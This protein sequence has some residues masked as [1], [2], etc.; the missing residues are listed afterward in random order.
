MMATD[1]QTRPLA[2]SANR[3]RPKSSSPP[4]ALERYLL[5]KLLQFAG[6]PLIDVRMW[7]DSTAGPSDEAAKTSLHFRNRAAFYSV[8]RRGEMGFGDC[9]SDGSLEV[10]GDLVEFLTEMFAAKRR[11]KNDLNW[12]L[13]LYRKLTQKKARQNTLAGSKSNIHHHYDIGNEFYSLWLDQ[14]AMQYT[15]AYFARPDYSIEQAQVAKLEHICRK[16]MLQPGQTVVEAGCGWG[17]LARYMAKHYGV[18]V[19]SYNISHEQIVYARERA[20]IEG[21]AGQVE[22]IEDDYRNIKDEFDVFVSIGMLEHVGKRNY[23]ALGSVID[24]CLAKNGRALVHSIGRNAPELMSGWIEK[25]IFPGAYPPTV[26]EMMDIVEPYDF[27]ILDI[28]NLR[29]HYA[30]TLR[31]WLARY[32][33]NEETVR[34]MFDEPFVRAWRLYLSGSIAAFL[35]GSL[36]LFQMVFA[37]GTDNRV[38]FTREHLYGASAKR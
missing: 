35:V 26:R 13:R 6:S 28:E 17:G 36:Q 34:Q 18:R 29:L 12:K 37:R 16:L 23:K 10:H 7:D 25:R 2:M 15:C 38:P 20:E 24:R 19:K 3:M 11:Q 5:G 31:H 33:E 4:F 27:S 8:L 9:Y 22:Y 1:R 21:L 14:E 32:N 30:E